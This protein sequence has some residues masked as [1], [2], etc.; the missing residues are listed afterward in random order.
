[1]LLNFS[2]LFKKQTLS[3]ASQAASV[4]DDLTQLSF[5]CSEWTMLRDGNCGL[6][7]GS[8]RAEVKL[9]GKR[10]LMKKNQN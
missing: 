6:V 5:I 2:Q 10:V 3:R 9:D 4:D 8:S 7:L 1:M